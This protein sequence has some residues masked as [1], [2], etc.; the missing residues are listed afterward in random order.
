MWSVGLDCHQRLYV[1]C[2]LD[3]NGKELLLRK[4]RGG[5]KQLREVLLGLKQ[6]FQICY[7]ASC[8]Y[9]VLHDRL[10]RLAAR[11]LVAHPGQLRLIFRSK[12][13]NDRVDARKLAT[14]LF[15]DQVPQVHVPSLDVRAWR[16]MIEFRSRT[17]GKRTRVKCQLR[18]L[19]RSHGIDA[20]S[21]KKL[22]TK[23]GRTWLA[24]VSWASARA[25]LQRDLLLEELEHF[26]GQLQRVERELDATGQRHP[27]VVVLRTIP[28]VGPRT[29]EA[30][31]AWIDQPQRFRRLKCIGS[32][33]GLVPRQDQS[34]G[35][36]RLGHITKDGPRTVRKLLLEAS[37][38][39]VRRSRRA[40]RFYEQIRRDDPNRKK[41]AIVATAHWL[42][43]MML[44]MLQTGAVWEE[45]DLAVAA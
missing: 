25:A 19:L 27:G 30:V 5:W 8:G 10:Q 44:R 29:A 33:F 2:V 3:E 28:G 39:A 31:V 21:G 7:E 6:P 11:I 17:V 24:A 42:S 22:W 35:T 18:A 45:Q 13:K 26:D 32:Y 20:A 12:R 23:A 43:R 40:E 4:I 16:Q 36:N 34:A 1:I 14:L 41:I 37:W 9:G 38:Q 15:L